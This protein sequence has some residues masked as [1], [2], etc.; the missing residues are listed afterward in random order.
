MCDPQFPLDNVGENV[1]QYF[2]P[3]FKSKTPEKRFKESRSTNSSQKGLKLIKE[4]AES[5]EKWK[6]K[7]KYKKLSLN[8][9]EQNFYLS[10]GNKVHAD[11]S[12]FHK[13]VSSRKQK[14]NSD[15]LTN[16]TSQQQVRSIFVI[17]IYY[18]CAQIV[19]FS[20]YCCGNKHFVYNYYKIQS[21][22]IYYFVRI[23]KAILF[24]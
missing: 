9:S 10:K 22:R 4:P 21:R 16:R 19:E 15:T 2:A 13:H 11:K 1:E 3:E 7:I 18:S 17:I 8:S 23:L 12:I 5:P 14:G 24:Q 20:I 6:S